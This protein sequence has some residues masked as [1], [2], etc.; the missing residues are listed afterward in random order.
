MMP[1]RATAMTRGTRRASRRLTA[2][3]SRKA[4][5]RARAKG[6]RSSRAKNRMRTV[7]ASTRKGPTLE[8]SLLRAWD[9]Q[10]RGTGWVE[11]LV[12]ARIHQRRRSAVG[13]GCA[14]LRRTG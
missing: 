12:G 6:I 10:P 11:W 9:I 1:V 5:V 3:A 7:T 4:R 8:N 13:Y 2:G 14:G